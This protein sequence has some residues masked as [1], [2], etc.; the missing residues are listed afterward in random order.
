MTQEYVHCA[1]GVRYIRFVCIVG[2][3]NDVS[4]NNHNKAYAIV[5]SSVQH[6]LTQQSY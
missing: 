1:L 4:I 2:A 6:I 3:A 5:I